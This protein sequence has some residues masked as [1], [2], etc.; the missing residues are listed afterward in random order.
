MVTL[1]DADSASLAQLFHGIVDQSVAGIYLIQHERMHYVN[2]R[3]AELF[4]TVPERIVGRRVREITPPGQRDIL[5]GH[6][7][8]RMLGQDSELHFVLKV[9]SRERG[10]RLIEYHGTKVQY[11]DHPALVGVAIDVTERERAHEEVV[12]SRTQLRALMSDIETIQDRERARIAL[13][14]HDVIGGILTALKFDIARL[15]RRF[16]SADQSDAQ[17]GADLMARTRDLNELAQEAIDAVRRLS[18][19]LRP[20]AL[21]HLGLFAAIQELGAQFSGRYGID[22]SV[23]VPAEPSAADSAA[24]LDIYRIIQEALTNIARHASASRAAISLERTGDTLVT[25]IADDGRGLTDPAGVTGPGLGLFGIRERARRI[26][27]TTAIGNGPLGGAR[28]AVR[29]PWTFREANL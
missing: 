1:E 23:T 12:R 24:E 17:T 14:L 10:E 8:R 2:N 26:G 16:E 20:R 29:A 19:E 22:C 9:S 28:I 5:M 13:E 7:R 11:R 18:E 4:G 6:I 3:Y 21:E 15:R 25:V 27:G